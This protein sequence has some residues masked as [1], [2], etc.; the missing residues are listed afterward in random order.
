MDD[1]ERDKTEAANYSIKSM[2]DVMH[3]SGRHLR[4][5]GK[6]RGGKMEIKIIVGGKPVFLTLERLAPHI[7][8]VYDPTA[9]R[10]WICKFGGIA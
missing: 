8:S 9:G 7:W 3:G 4:V 5:A 1:Q 2:D 6:I 10:L